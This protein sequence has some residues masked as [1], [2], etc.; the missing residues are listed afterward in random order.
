MKPA[1]T[2]PF[3][4]RIEILRGRRRS[5][6]LSLEGGRF[7][8]RVP[9]GAAGPRLDTA[10]ERLR[11][12]LWERLRRES[13]WTDEDLFALSESVAEQN[14]RDLQLP[15]WT[16][17]FSR[18][19]N[20]RWGSCTFDGRA[21]RIRISAHLIGHPRWVIGQVLL[22]ELLHLVVQDHGP[23]FQGLLS[24][25]PDYERGRGYLEALETLE[26]I[27]PH[28]TA[29]LA[30]EEDAPGQAVLFSREQAG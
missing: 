5:L 17:R 26:R 19:Q 3:P 20:K 14:L 18:R 12:E 24:R 8:A 21:G 27:G 1:V 23:R 28:L 11:S 16:A 2:D 22:H 25:D 7:V 15:P 30:L 4:R 9:A 10:L 13:V 29:S 6:Q